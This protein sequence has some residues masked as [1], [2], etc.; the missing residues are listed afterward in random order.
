MKKLLF[1]LFPFLAAIFI[2][3]YFLAGQAVYGDGIYYWSYVRSIYIDHDLALNDEIS[4]HYDH[5]HNNMNVTNLIP[6]ED[7]ERI[8]LEYH[9]PFGVSLGWLPFFAIGDGIARIAHF[10]NKTVVLNGYSDIYQIS[11]GI[12]N[13][14]YMLG[15]LYAVYL[16]LKKYFSEKVAVI[17]TA[18]LFFTTDL[19]YYG[20]W[21]VIN[22]HPFSFFL[23]SILVYF[24]FCKFTYKWNQWILLGALIGGLILTRT[25]EVVFG[26]F[27]LGALLKYWLTDKEVIFKKL[28]NLIIFGLLGFLGVVLITF[29]QLLL[30]QYV[31]HGLFNSPYV[32]QGS[33]HFLTPQ[34]LGVLI[35]S[36][37]GLL[38]TS[39]SVVVGVIGL[40]LLA[41]QKKYIGVT[42]LALFLLEYYV[43]ASWLF[44]DQAASYGIRML[45]AT[46]PI[47]ALGLGYV[48]KNTAKRFSY[49][50]AYVV[51]VLLFFFNVAMIVRFEFFVKTVTIDGVAVTRIEAQKKLNQIFHT[52]FQFFK[53]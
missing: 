44:W 42:G 3:H 31:Y 53:K 9:L 40:I 25:Q 35:N 5:L 32:L 20:S 50:L 22:S 23:S 49:K 19:F 24:F 51:G 52:N 7:V 47:V 46:L 37:T 29:P 27:L 15:G 16:L 17:T 11:V 14:L 26:I 41:K 45:I 36:K 10:L 2:F 12:G 48:I 43:I 38:F 39:P 33:F 8:A 6:K 4:H 28:Q 21:D 30:L 1:L 34:L 13:I 18:L